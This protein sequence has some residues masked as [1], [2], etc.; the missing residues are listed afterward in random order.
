MVRLPSAIEAARKNLRLLVTPWVRY[1]E[2][3]LKSKPLES[4][5]SWVEITR[6][7]PI[8]GLSLRVASQ[9]QVEKAGRSANRHR[10]H[11]CEHEGFRR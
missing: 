5:E 11:S 3:L 2:A 1:M 8:P 7:G 9:I 4:A 6:D 10:R